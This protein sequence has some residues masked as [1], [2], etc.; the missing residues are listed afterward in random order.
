MKYGDMPKGT[1]YKNELGSVWICL[2][3]GKEIFLPVG[4]VTNVK[5]SEEFPST[6]KVQTLIP[7]ELL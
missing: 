1:I 5:V 7:L 2:G 4:C 6:L 3:E